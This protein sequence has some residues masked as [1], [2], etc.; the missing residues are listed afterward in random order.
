MARIQNF[1]AAKSAA[2]WLY[3]VAAATAVNSIIL[4]RNQRFIDLLVGLS[5]TQFVDAMFLGFGVEPQGSPDWYVDAV[6]ALIIDALFLCVLVVLAVKIFHGSR[7]AA[8]VGLWAY[9]VDTLVF[10]LIFV[11]SIWALVN[12]SFHAPGTAIAWQGSTVVA[13]VAGVFILFRAL[14]TG[15]SEDARRDEIPDH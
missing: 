4:N 10:G 11:T 8:K 2:A 5:F 6:P 3:L 13:H 12:G 9:C 15:A 14:R 1:G 7:I